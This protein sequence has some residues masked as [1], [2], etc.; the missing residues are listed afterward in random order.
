MMV[1]STK[2]PWP[3]VILCFTRDMGRS[4]VIWDGSNALPPESRINSENWVNLYLGSL[5]R[6][7]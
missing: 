1:S 2:N 3:Y 4:H 6:G 7:R 5:Y